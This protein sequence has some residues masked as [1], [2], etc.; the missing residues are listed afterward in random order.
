M[1]LYNNQEKTT[2][3]K[4]GRIVVIGSSNTDMVISSDRLPVP[5]QIVAGGRFAMNSGG[6]GANQAIAV[7]RMGG[8]VS[9]I[10]KTGNDLFGRQSLEV[11][12]SEGI[13]SDYVFSDS[14]H[15][16]G[17]GLI[18]V[19][20]SGE[21][22]ISIAQGAIKTLSIEEIEKARTEIENA[23][24]LLMELE[25]PMETAEYIAEIASKSGVT[26]ILNPS[27]IQLISPKLL[28]QVRII[29][30][31]KTEA[32]LLTGILINDWAS[33]RKAADSLHEKG[34]ETVIITLGAR[35]ALILDK[36]EYYEIP[37]EDVEAIDTTAAG[38]TFCG[39]LCV[40]LTEGMSIV[41]AAEM[42][43]KAASI[44]VTRKGMQE[45]IPYR[46][47]LKNLK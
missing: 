12:K 24:I 28:R 42:A 15:P 17:V 10:T 20:S 45:A 37:A 2:G 23:D 34:I 13:M 26:V 30:P 44:T 46:D 16:S 47:E 18:M 36:G 39:A 3:Q 27:P 11:Y 31:N 32:G 5:G 22:Y 25:I 29:I 9:F 38:D 41:E 6:K 19:D 8:N 7:A 14:D 33:A 21:K 43:N 40:G 1:F 35:G 4:M